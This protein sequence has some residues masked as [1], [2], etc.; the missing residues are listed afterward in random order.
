VSASA[1]R[2]NM[3]VAV[4][5]ARN[6]PT[7]QA[8]PEPD[9]VTPVVQSFVVHR[10]MAR[11]VGGALDQEDR[12][13]NGNLERHCDRR[14]SRIGLQLIFGLDE[15]CV[16]SLFQQS[17]DRL[18][19][20]VITHNPAAEVLRQVRF[21]EGKR[22]AVGEAHT[23]DLHHRC[24]RRDSELLRDEG[25][26]RHNLATKHAGGGDPPQDPHV[27]HEACELGEF[28]NNPRRRHEGPSSAPNLHQALTHEVLDRRPDGGPA[29]VE[30]A[31]QFVFGWELGS[32]RQRAARNAADENILDLG[33]K[34]QPR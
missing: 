22:R 14:L 30:F 16:V 4:R 24:P 13:A 23:L 20:K 8:R 31:D 32:D 18:R 10:A 6:G 7:G 27:L 26:S 11:G 17:E 28:L 21:V 1:R 3:P 29:D 9:G 19:G 12:G 34:R 33:V 15:R 2:S 5:R 25:N